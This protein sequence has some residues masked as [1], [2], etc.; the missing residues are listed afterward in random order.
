ME[1][2]RIAVT[3]MGAV[4]PIGN[5]VEEFWPALQQGRSGVG[6]ITSFD[7]EG[8][9]CRIAAEVRDLDFEQHFDRKENRKLESF[10]KYGIIAAREAVRE[11]GILD[12][13]LP[14]EEIGCI[15]GVGIGG[16]EF[17]QN[18]C[19]KL[20]KNGPRRT[21]PL[22][23][24]RIIANIAP[25]HI[26]IDLGLKGPSFAVV[27]ACAAGTHAIGESCYSILRGDCRAVIAG[28]CESC[29]CEIGIAGF[30]N[31]Q[32]LAS[33][34]Y[35]N[36]EEASC[37]FDA[38]RSGFVMGEGSGMLVLEDYEYARGRGANILAEIIGYGLSSDAYHITAPSPGGVGGA[39]AMAQAIE[40]AGIRPDEV[41]YVNAHGTSTPLNDRNETEAIKSVLGDH[42]GKVAISSNKSMI[43]HLLGA[44]GAVE[45]IASIKTILDGVI[46]PTINYRDA[47]PE[48]DLD[49]VPNEKRDA[50]VGVV[51]S[52]SLGF[53][54]HNCSI[55]LR[56]AAN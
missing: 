36:P 46:P 9:N 51:M 42:A 49:Y 22:V 3:G 40:R 7:T 32:A 13:G 37:P 26:S 16:I 11:S 6:P 10:V 33:H 52:N 23:I 47:D 34:G 53:G 21:S 8:Y 17:S 19:I 2:G 56:R 12:S 14:P 41:D 1:P 4:T 30:G 20:G 15:T 28:G 50:E 39:R 45:A 43:G 54:G 5:T 48:C 25:G 27:S 18:E 24:P 44:A 29:I 35:E 38:K 55:I 31:M